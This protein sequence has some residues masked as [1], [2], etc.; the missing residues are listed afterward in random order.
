MLSK[1]GVGI[2]LVIA[3]IL[4][5]VI[6]VVAQLVASTRAATVS[7]TESAM[8]ILS[9]EG[10][11]HA[12]T[13]ENFLN[14]GLALAADARSALKAVRSLAIDK[15]RPPDRAEAL[16]LL[17]ALAQDNTGSLGLWTVWAPDAFDGADA[18]FKNADAAHDASGRFVPY[19]LNARGGV[20]VEPL[21][22]YDQPGAG[23]YNLLAFKSGRPTVLEPFPYKVEG[24]EVLVTTLALPIVEQGRTL[25]TV[26]ADFSL[27]SIST[28]ISRIK[29]MG[30]GQV[31]LISPGGL[32]AGHSDSSLVG[33]AF[34]DTPRG[35]VLNDLIA[36][37]QK[38]GQ[39]FR[40]VVPQG[41]SAAED[42]VVAI[43]LFKPKDTQDNWAFIATVPMTTI[44]AGT[45][46]LIRQGLVIGLIILALTIGFGMLAVKVVVGGLTRRIMTV[47]HSLEDGT[48]ELERNAREL[49]AS[50]HNIADGAQSQ[51]AALEETSAALEE[52][53]SMTKKSAENAGDTNQQTRLTIN[54][55]ATSRRDMEKL[56]EA[57]AGINE[58]TLQIAGI[59]KAIEDIAFQTNLLALNAA[60]EAARAGEAGSG[61]AVVAE[62][63]RNLA[64]RS[65]ESA[66]ST[67]ALIDETTQRVKN[68]SDIVGHLTESFSEVAEG[69][70]RI[71]AL[72]D[73]IATASNEQDTGIQ[74]VSQATNDMDK[75]TQ[76]NAG[77][78]TALADSTAD[79][80]RQAENINEAI[81]QLLATIGNS[82]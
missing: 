62:E 63:V 41:W 40:M 17:K 52:I 81:T 33:R 35:Q 47:V 9:E 11:R 77:A 65:A 46:E 8:S 2:Q 10:G 44:Q 64:T 15:G 28:F 54:M 12:V 56:Q 26:G 16:G 61:F 66:R 32:V 71:S 3:F 72:I 67:T 80:T 14:Q 27:E 23:D 29:P 38:T 18:S 20:T 43:K 78:V 75:V 22:G 6:A 55:M 25:G 42:A 5:A 45:R 68:G 7:A 4:V 30:V 74:Q 76:E 1:I 60:V 82:H 49:T 69:A 13:V 31:S 48:R 39:E 36:E 21:V 59:I 51:A 34:K 37:A 58:A 53:S 79:L 24:R 50:S 57:M 70:D 73:Q 19:C